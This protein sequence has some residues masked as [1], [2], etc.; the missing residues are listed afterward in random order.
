MNKSR[1]I[2]KK[3]TCP[4]SDGT[5][6]P[7]IGISGCLVIGH[8]SDSTRSTSSNFQS[9]QNGKLEFRDIYKFCCLK[10]G[11]RFTVGLQSG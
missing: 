11:L 4:N 6:D 9:S 8:H 1:S 5:D 10:P 3:I 2:I 7:V